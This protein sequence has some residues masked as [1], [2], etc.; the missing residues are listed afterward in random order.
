[1][2]K[3]KKQK[4]IKII[5]NIIEKK[6]SIYFLWV[7]LLN[8]TLPSL[9][10]SQ[11]SALETKLSNPR[12]SQNGLVFS[13]QNSHAQMVELKSSFDQWT[14]RYP[15]EKK[16]EFGGFWN[17]IWELS[18][19]SQY[20]NFQL[21]QGKYHYKLLIDGQFTHDPLNLNRE[22]DP[23]GGRIS[24]FT[25]EQDI[26]DYRRIQNP[27]PVDSKKE[28]RKYRF[29]YRD[30]KAQKVYLVGNMNQ[31]NSY[32]HPFEYKGNGLWE[33]E[34]RLLKGN[35][36]YHFIVDGKW[37]KDPINSQTKENA[38]GRSYSYFEVKE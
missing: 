38:L 25:L 16:M 7:F 36:E 23:R 5:K 3:T 22:E 20:K 24:Y 9:L 19:S 30:L 29:V 21:K 32:S 31:W 14:W 13:Y 28:G 10:K 17:G 6:I 15:F 35:Y 4:S 1:M 18:L 11:Q 26:L 27:Y 8:F 2:V 12:I 37:K 34:I 33:I